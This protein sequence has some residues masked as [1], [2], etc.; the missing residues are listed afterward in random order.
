MK[1]VKRILQLAIVASCFPFAAHATAYK[2]SM[3]G[4]Q[5]TYQDTPCQSGV[6][7]QSVSLTNSSSALVTLMA[8]VA[9][10]GLHTAARRQQRLGKI[11]DAVAGCLASL[12]GTQFDD[13][14]QRA[15]SS[16]MSVGDLQAANTFFSSPSGRKFGKLIISQVYVTLGEPSPDSAPAMTNREEVDIQRFISTG[17]GQLLVNQR[18]IANSELA[19]AINARIDELKKSCGMHR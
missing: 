14:A 7:Q 18:F 8:D 13:A 15:L 2:C 17:A 10:V 11:P 6:A 5:T 1:A 9:M 12:K 3:P 16:S 19:P 4:G